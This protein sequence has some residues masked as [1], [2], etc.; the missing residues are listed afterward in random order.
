VAVEALNVETMSDE[1]AIMEEALLARDPD[2]RQLTVDEVIL[3]QQ[4]LTSAHLRHKIAKEHE[5]AAQRAH[6]DAV[7]AAASERD[8]LT[9]RE[10][11][12]DADA[13]A[14]A[15][16]TGHTNSVHAQSGRR[17]SHIDEQE[18]ASSRTSY[19]EALTKATEVAADNVT[20]ANRE[21]QKD[22]EARG[23]TDDT[24]R[25][26]FVHK[27]EAA[28]IEENLVKLQV[29]RSLAAHRD[30][31]QRTKTI[32]VLQSLRDTLAV[33]VRE[34]EASSISTLAVKLVKVNR[35]IAQATAEHQVVRIDL[36]AMEM[37]RTV[38]NLEE[39]ALEDHDSTAL[40]TA[41]LITRLTSE[42]HEQAKHSLHEALRQGRIA[43]KQEAIVRDLEQ[44]GRVGLQAAKCALAITKAAEAEA[45]EDVHGA[46]TADEITHLQTGLKSAA[47]HGAT[48]A[49][50]TELVMATLRNQVAQGRAAKAH[51]AHQDAL[52]GAQ[53]NSSG[54]PP[55][56]HAEDLR[57]AAMMESTV[58]LVAGLEAK[59]GTTGAQNGTAAPNTDLETARLRVE[60]ATE[61]VTRANATN[62]DMQRLAKMLDV[63]QARALALEAQQLSATTD[64]SSTQT[65]QN[66]IAEDLEATLHALDLAR[67]DHNVALARNGAAQAALSMASLGIA[68]S[69]DPSTSTVT[70][71]DINAAEIQHSLAEENYQRERRNHLRILASHDQ[72][73]ALEGRIKSL[74]AQTDANPSA[75]PELTGTSARKD[76]LQVVQGAYDTALV[77][78]RIAV[79]TEAEHEAAD[80]VETMAAVAAAAQPGSPEQTAAEVE[81]E[82]EKLHLKL[83]HERAGR[84]RTAQQRVFLTKARV[85]RLASGGADTSTAALRSVKEQLDHA[86]H[87]NVIASAA[88]DAVIAKGEAAT[89]ADSILRDP[90]VRNRAGTSPRDVEQVRAAVQHTVKVSSLRSKLAHE[91][92]ARLRK[93]HLNLVLTDAAIQKAVVTSQGDLDHSE[94]SPMHNR[95]HS[96][97]VLLHPSLNLGST[98]GDASG[99]SSS[100]D[101]IRHASA[102]PHPGA[103]RFQSRSESQRE[104]QHHADRGARP[105]HMIGLPDVPSHIVPHHEEAHHPHQIQ[106]SASVH[107]HAHHKVDD[108][109]R[110]DDP[111]NGN[112]VDF[113]HSHLS[114]HPEVRWSKSRNSES[115]RVSTLSALNELKRAQH[116]ADQT[117]ERLAVVEHTPYALHSI[118]T[119][120]VKMRFEVER[121]EHRLMLAKIR[122]DQENDQEES[123]N[124]GQGTLPRKLAV[125]PV[126]GPRTR[127][128][129]ILPPAPPRHSTAHPRG[130]GRTETARRTHPRLP[131]PT[132]AREGQGI[133][134]D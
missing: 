43:H 11:A 104:S 66:L 27:L 53:L 21:L 129:S 101:T 25:S 110:P 127:G 16:S 40:M 5:H 72:L 79:L 117:R 7:M 15:L 44:S 75:P 39:Q 95:Y 4:M 122:S 51:R 35:D 65:M 121:A 92:A 91:R 46:A 55:T 130:S 119:D 68:R 23:D 96:P 14:L 109:Y 111:A 38:Q 64:P 97:E 18:D 6:H 99:V 113:R 59:L 98:Q 10:L 83:A 106:K 118:H 70:E 80:Q 33:Q 125:N 17:T 82:I 74:R 126:V 89:L 105:H 107:V 3:L 54:D 49:L 37:A 67:S 90:T 86:H 20:H 132:S 78:S 28:Q 112:T 61:R 108:H 47:G 102:S 56:S 30:L 60:L 124:S 41:K 9:G 103:I 131:Q 13:N 120:P 12:I 69:T 84:A 52:S 73:G 31:S 87:A 58:E 123:S 57:G 93:D 62:R 63:L 42:R 85:Q 26:I 19:T 29:Q 24:S 134:V 77:E 116:E 71:Y 8:P 32:E 2:E 133:V 88:R 94:P 100:W 114:A 22:V 45:L 50:E 81:L 128:G 34:A 48:D 76:V 36:H 115:K 1:V